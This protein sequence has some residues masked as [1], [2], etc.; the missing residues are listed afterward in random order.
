MNRNKILDLVNIKLRK[1]RPKVPETFNH[2]LWIEH[3]SSKPFVQLWFRTRGCRHNYRGGCTMCDYWISDLVSPEQMVASVEEGLGKLDFEP[4]MILLN[5]SGSVF[6]DWEVPPV[7]RQKIL[8]LL[9]RYRKTTFIF[10][11]RA[12]TISS[13][14]IAECVKILKG[15]NIIIEMG[16]ES[17]DPWVLKYC[18]NKSLE[19]KN[20]ISAVQTLKKF[21]VKSIAN[22][23][24]GAP[25]LTFSETI[26][27]VVNSINWAFEHDVNQCVL[28]P[29]NI[30]PWTLMY[31]LEQYGIYT[32]PSLWIL[33]DVISKLDIRLLPYVHISWYKARPQSHP[34]YQESN[35]SPITCPKCY[36]NVIRLLNEYNSSDNRARILEKLMEL[37]CDCKLQWHEQIEIKPRQSLVE[38]VQTNYEVIARQILGE[39]WWNQYGEATLAEIESPG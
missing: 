19:L 30:K 21:N 3:Q 10:E 24:A 4:D 22:I 27:D 39:Q 32:L 9:S 17:T 36:D 13:Q 1:N 18:I 26:K 34:L 8:E 7:A 29:M 37:S 35:R 14:K 6:D 5:S 31:W 20:V 15:R 23:L 2:T 16:F 11:T 28:F 25:F 38:R 12:E 33:V